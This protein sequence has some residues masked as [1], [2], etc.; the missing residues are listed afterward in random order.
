MRAVAEQPHDDA[1]GRV[2]ALAGALIEA[3]A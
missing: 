1:P 2:L 3:L